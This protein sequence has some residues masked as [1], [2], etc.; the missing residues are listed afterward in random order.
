MKI[1]IV[2]SWPE[3]LNISSYNVQE[4]GLARAMIRAG[5]QCDIVLYQD[6]SGSRIQK[7]QDGIT[8]YW[9]H[10]L[11]LCKNGLFPGLGRII[12]EYDVIQVH[13]YD[14]LQSWFLYTFSNKR[15]VLYHGPY[16]DVFNRGYNLKCTVFD[17]LFLPWS[18]KALKKRPCIT[19]SP[20]AA[21][22]IQKKG[23]KDVISL[24]VGLNAEN[25]GDVT[26][27]GKH[28]PIIDDMPDDQ[29]NILYVGKLEAR[30]NISFLLQIL[31]KITQTNDKVHIT[32]I[33]SGTMQYLQMIQPEMC[34]ME[35]AG[36]LSC[37]DKCPQKELGN[38]YKKADLMLF[39]SNYEIFG[40][41][42]MEAMY[43][44]VACISSLNGGSSQLIESGVDGIV[45]DKAD[46]ESWVTQTQALIDDRNRLHS[47]QQNAAAKIRDFY[48]WDCLAEKFIAVYERA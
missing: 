37:F 13:E 14:Q 34:E 32:V 29:L 39:P 24:G 11:N 21:D 35:N 31:K 1:L 25:F 33:G 12:R 40:M 23:F 18:G 20:L 27:D 45:L 36:R 4:I 6:Q 46:M 41:T 15:I 8:I 17:H 42:L 7:S 44:G 10:A 3:Q 16:Y 48:Q 9:I 30:R 38:V 22:F 47:I 43:F 26:Y 2:R 19:K 5:H 28:H